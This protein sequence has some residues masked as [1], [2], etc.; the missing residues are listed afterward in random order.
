MQ[1]KYGDML[2]DIRP[3]DIYLVTTNS[4][5]RK[6]GA[7][8]M[9][10]GAAKQLAEMYPNIPYLF[11]KSIAADC[12]HLGEYNVGVLTDKGSNTSLGAFQV[13]F[14]FKDEA[15]LELIQRS[16]N[17]LHT[18]AC[19]DGRIF[20]LNYPGIGNGRRRISEVSYML[21]ELPDNVNVWRFKQ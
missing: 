14:H 3:G 2:A 9:G 10:R 16:V 1:H 21:A 13:K 4:F 18:L 6:D 19:E 5:I 11:G 20:H 12:G 7:V 17:R 8:V 15:D